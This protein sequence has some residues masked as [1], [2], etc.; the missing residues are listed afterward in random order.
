MKKVISIIVTLSLLLTFLCTSIAAPAPAWP[1]L[2]NG[3]N[4]TNVYSLQYLLVYH[5]YNITVDG[6]FGPGT[7]TA[8][9]N[10]QTSKGLYPDGIVGT[11]TW[12]KLVVTV[13]TNSNN[14][15]VK[16]LQYQLKNKYGYSITVD[17]AF[18][19]GTSSAV[20]NLQAK[21]GLEPDAIVGP[22]TW[23]YIM[24]NSGPISDFF[25]S[26]SSWLRPLK[27]ASFLDPLEGVRAFGRS[28]NSS[29]RT[30]AGIDFVADPGT[31]V[32]SMTSGTVIYAGDFDIG[33]GQVIVRNSDNTIARYCE[34][35]PS[36]T[37]ID[38]YKAGKTT[39]VSRGTELGYLIRNNTSE[40][41]CMLHLEVYQGTVSGG[42]DTLTNYSNNTYTY[43]PDGAY[44][45]YQRRS[46]LQ[47]PMGARNLPTY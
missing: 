6:A 43:V 2:K 18:G 19:P 36:Q 24:G 7:E 38:N 21:I 22:R 46:D 29:T 13:Q 35:Q 10:F 31:K 1:V 8:V 25:T 16:A 26:R 42:W 32:Y 30:H 27:D 9:K 4:G 11:N 34:M 23:Q 44:G 28:R 45:I 41:S 40:R 33:T 14:S 37:L 3:N 39:S 17:G 20:K 15:A 5:G 47:N 12:T